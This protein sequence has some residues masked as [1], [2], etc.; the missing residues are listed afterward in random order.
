M[1]LLE[2]TAI[3]CPYCGES[4][5]ILVDGSVEQQQYIEDC[6]VCCRPMEILVTIGAGGAVKVE[7]RH[8][9]E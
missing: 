5:T 9:N 6:E 7:V 1:S 4:I 2:E 3:A 8:E